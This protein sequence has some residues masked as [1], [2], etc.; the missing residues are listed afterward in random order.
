[1]RLTNPQASFHEFSNIHIKVTR[2]FQV[3]FS[4]DSPIPFDNQNFSITIKHVDPIDDAELMQ[5]IFAFRFEVY[6]QEYRFLS[7]KNYHQKKEIDEYDA[8][9]AHFCALSSQSELLGYVRLIHDQPNGGFPFQKHMA[10][11]GLS[12]EATLPNPAEC[13]EISRLMLCPSY[14]CRQGDAS[15]DVAG[16][17]RG[18]VQDRRAG[19]SYVLLCLYKQMYLYSLDNGIRYW[20]A[21]MERS[22][23]RS[24]MRLHFA[25]LKIGP[26]LDYYGPVAPYLADLRDLEKRSHHR[27]PLFLE[28]IRKKNRINPV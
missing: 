13:G 17:E 15:T 20:Y 4:C 10:Q 22:L 27:N 19:S 25:F 11:A 1:M 21:A 18:V 2:G 9:A 23:A 12:T 3:H 7:E 26:E 24:L 16:A 6:C 8:G 28:W 14:R 5:S